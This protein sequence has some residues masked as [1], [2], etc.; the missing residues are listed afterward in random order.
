MAIAVAA[1]CGY[2]IGSIPVGLIVGR[3]SGRVDVRDYGSG[4]TGFTNTLRLLG[5]RR[6]LSVFAGD[7]GKGLAAA[8]LPL[9]YS[10]DAWARAAGGLAAI[11][12]HVWPLFAGFRGGRGV[13]AGGGALLALSPPA[14]ALV[15]PFAGLTLYL[16]RYMSLTSIVGC[17]AA[18]LIFLAFAAA[19][20]LPWAYA[21]VV[22]AGGG[23]I[24]LLH[25]D[26]IGRLLAGHEPKIG[27][28]GERRPTAEEPG[29]EG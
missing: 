19:D 13:L 23:L 2:L 29:A 1:V 22:A 7:L 5:L 21:A 8:L 20:E 28:G 15:L 11:V 6:S 24:V 4:K 14:A 26:N 17:L 3:L 10:D 27:Q 9:L 25:R 18:A 12:G 16:S